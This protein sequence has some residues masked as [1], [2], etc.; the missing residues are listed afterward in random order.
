MKEKPSDWIRLLI[1][2]K[3]KCN[4]CG[5][6]ISSGEYALWSR[7]SK[8]I[9]H[10]K[11]ET[12]EE[13]AK[14][15]SSLSIQPLQLECFICGRNTRCNECGFEGDYDRTIVSQAFI[16]NECLIDHNAYENYQQQFIKK[17][18]TIARLKSNKF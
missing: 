3:G 8:A 7:A 4:E 11:C 2:Y 9:K 16:C 15:R 10:I 13:S 18:Q 14:K 12:Q 5:N 17:L 6:E 1:K